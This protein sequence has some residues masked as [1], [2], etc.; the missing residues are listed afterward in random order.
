MAEA[1]KPKGRKKKLE[2]LDFSYEPDLVPTHDKGKR[3]ITNKRAARER[4]RLCAEVL[5]PPTPPPSL[6][7]SPS[8]SLSLSLSLPLAV[9]CHREIL[10][11]PWK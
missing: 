3:R 8:L 5:S 7:F 2:K 10:A 11:P 1:K 4:Q 9:L 6:P